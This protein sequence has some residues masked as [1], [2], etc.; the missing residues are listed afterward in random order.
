MLALRY[1]QPGLLLKR[2]GDASPAQVRELQH[3]LRQ[4][5]YLREFIDGKYGSGTERAVRALQH[6][7]QKNDGR[8]RDGRAPVRVCDYNDGRV[9]RVTG[10]VN[11]NMVECISA[12]LDDPAFPKLPLATDPKAENRR[13]RARLAAL[14][15]GQVPVP[16]LMAVLMQ[17]S[18]LK[19]YREPGPGDEDAY[20]VVGLDTNAEADHIITSRGYGAGQY[21]LFH[22]PPAAAEVRDFVLDPARN[23]SKAAGELREKFDRFVAGPTAN[24]RADDRTA[25]LG[26]GPLRLCKYSAGD[27][28]YMTDCV[29]CARDAGLVNIHSGSTPVFAGS[30]LKFAPTQYYKSGSYTGVPRRAGIGCDWPYAIRRYNGA[31]I[32]SYHYQAR[33]LLHL[34]NLTQG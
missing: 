16:F 23:V 18:G 26:A 20:I 25:E 1:R 19:H 5:G 15:A 10:M 33:V 31:G 9:G 4:L 7:L 2:G 3:H 6:D 14:P 13:V 34:L 12:M 8:G 24:T 27:S 32:N 28:R 22:H 29:Q 17:E 11:Q 21:T 30:S